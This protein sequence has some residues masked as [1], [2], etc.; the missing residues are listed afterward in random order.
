MHE[1]NHYGACEK[2]IPHTIDFNQTDRK[3]ESS[4]TTVT[5]VDKV[6]KQY[7]IT[8]RDNN[9]L[10][11]QAKMFCTIGGIAVVGAVGFLIYHVFTERRDDRVINSILL[12][13]VQA[14]LFLGM[15]LGIAKVLVQTTEYTLAK[16]T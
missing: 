7:L 14:V 9:R 8:E 1:M 11:C 6:S 10:D 15:G 4:C 13:L 2:T 12:L 16:Q 5:R 3:N